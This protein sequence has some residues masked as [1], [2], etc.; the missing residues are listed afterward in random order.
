MEVWHGVA[1]WSCFRRFPEA[2]AGLRA[3]DGANP[4]SDAGS[5]LIAADLCLAELRSVSEIPGVERFPGLL[6][7]KTRW[8]SVFR[9][10]GALQADQAG[11][12]AR[13]GRRVQAALRAK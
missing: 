9:D 6:A 2:G 7:G 10:G 12:A 13:G 3:D 1:G 11:R 8:P 5:S 4:V